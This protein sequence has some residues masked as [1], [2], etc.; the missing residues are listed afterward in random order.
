[1]ETIGVYIF[2][3]FIVVFLAWLGN[4]IRARHLREKASELT[5][6]IEEQTDLY[7]QQS[8]PDEPLTLTSFN[9]Q[10]LTSMGE[11]LL[12]IAY[13]KNEKTQTPKAIN[14]VTTC[15]AFEQDEDGFCTS[16]TLNVNM[17]DPDWYSKN[18]EAKSTKTFLDK[19]DKVMA[20][21]YV[22]HDF[23]LTQFASEMATSKRHLNRKMLL[24]IGITPVQAIRQ[25][26]L[27]R[28]AEKLI[29]GDCPSNV[30]YDVGFASHSYFSSCF[31]NRYNCLPCKYMMVN[32]K[33]NKNKDRNI[34]SKG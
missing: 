28:A 19:L 29:K 25:Y 10:R 5:K 21:N 4:K 30:A 1:M 18:E 26:R 27:T 14:R 33:T 23:N 17:A 7:Q 3:C 32:D 20:D 13:S 12:V 31:K 22:K 2:C 34:K 8:Q 16:E 15:S 11:Q 24:L 9:G 6:T